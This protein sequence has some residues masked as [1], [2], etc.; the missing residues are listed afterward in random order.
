MGKFAFGFLFGIGIAVGGLIVGG[1]MIAFGQVL[2]AIREIAIN[3]RKETKPDEYKILEIAATLN[4]AIGWIVIG[5]G[6]V[7]GAYSI[8]MSIRP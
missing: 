3:T 8:L 2:L 5:G 6:L 1:L 7:F 4:N